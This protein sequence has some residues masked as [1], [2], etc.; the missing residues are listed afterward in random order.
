MAYD[1]VLNSYL[2]DI[3]FEGRQNILDLEWYS[4]FRIKPQSSQ[5]LTTALTSQILDRR[6]PF[7]S[8]HS[9]DFVENL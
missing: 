5:K 4:S 1:E 2:Q 8:L 9:E 7:P 6:G 3:K